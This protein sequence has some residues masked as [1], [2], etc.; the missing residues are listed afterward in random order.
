MESGLAER[1]WSKSYTQKCDASIIC[2]GI[3][4]FFIMLAIVAV[5]FFLFYTDEIVSTGNYNGQTVKYKK[6]KKWI[7][8]HL[9]GKTSFLSKIVFLISLFLS[10]P[11]VFHSYALGKE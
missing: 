4:N 1:S 11:N 9:I 8:I 7:H 2:D 10:E 5:F 3:F 6:K